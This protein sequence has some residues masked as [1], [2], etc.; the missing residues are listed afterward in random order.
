[1]KE[2]KAVTQPHSVIE[3]ITSS[4]WEPQPGETE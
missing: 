4:R 1:M 2:I 3:A